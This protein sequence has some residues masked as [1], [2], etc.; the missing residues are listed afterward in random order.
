MNSKSVLM[1]MVMK[2]RAM[3]PEYLHLYCTAGTT[4]LSSFS[5]YTSLLMPTMW[6][7]SWWGIFKYRFHY[8]LIPVN[9]KT[10][11]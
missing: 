7:F 3:V 11:L 4:T 10:S 1:E 2:V 6:Y 5:P 9:V 8:S